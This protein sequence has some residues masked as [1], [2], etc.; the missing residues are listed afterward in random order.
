MSKDGNGDADI[1]QSKTKKG[2]RRSRKKSKRLS[3]SPSPKSEKRKR[4]QKR[5]SKWDAKP[6]ESQIQFQLNSQ[7]LQKQMQS[8]PPGAIPGLSNLNGL[9]MTGVAGIARAAQTMGIQSLMQPQIS[10]LT[11]KPPEIDR[12]PDLEE[13]RAKLKRANR[14]LAEGF[15]NVPE[16]QRSPSPEPIYSEDGKRLNTR[17]IRFKNEVEMERYE[18]MSKLLEKTKF[19]HPIFGTILK[20]GLKDQNRGLE[21]KIWIPVDKMPDYNFAGVII[22]PRGMSQKRLEKESGCSIS[23]RGKG[24]KKRTTGK[25]FEGDD[26]PQHVLIKAPN[27]ECLKKGI[28]VV[29]KALEPQSEEERRKQMRELA[30]LN[31]TLRELPPCPI[32]GQQGHKPMTCPQRNRF[33]AK[34]KCLICQSDTHVSKDC[35]QRTGNNAAGANLMDELGRFM[36]EI[37]GDLG[38][39]DKSESKTPTPSKPK[40]TTPQ[41]PKPQSQQVFCQPIPAPN[42]M[43]M[44]GARPGIGFVPGGGA[45][46]GMG[47]AGGM[48]NAG[49]MQNTAGMASGRG[50]PG[51][52]QNRFGTTARPKTPCVN[53]A[54]GMCRFGARCHFAH[55]KPNQPNMNINP[56]QPSRNINPNQPNM[57][58]NPNQPNMSINPNQPNVNQG[59]R[60][61][62]GQSQ[63]N[64]QRTDYNNRNNHNL[65][66]N[67]NP[68][69]SHGQRVQQMT[70]G[71]GPRNGTNLPWSGGGGQGPQ[72]Q[73]NTPWAQ[74]RNMQSQVPSPQQPQVQKRIP[75][76]YPPQARPPGIYSPGQMGGQPVYGRGRGMYGR[77]MH[78][79]QGGMAP[80]GMAPGGMARGGMARGG[81]APGGMA[82]VG[83]A[84]GGMSRSGMARGGM[85]PGSMNP[86]GMGP[87]RMPARPGMMP[88]GLNPGYQNPRG[89]AY[90]QRPG[91]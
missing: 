32:C 37:N 70:G 67:Q 65:P 88:P 31:G 55:I 74:G 78:M 26:Q 84:P 27:A 60:M 28:E 3:R 49:G 90:Q 29:K 36:A 57:N 5:V 73:Q 58:I 87:G 68:H 21:H 53:F 17:E 20:I 63:D 16:D 82:P 14:K 39:G 69:A 51:L 71:G 22:G 80:G 50:P 41:P 42:Q 4:K 1:D 30:I 33:Q 91:R 19:A 8:L 25:F 59:L 79:P 9:T 46:R 75:P 40:P 34:V 15:K 89:S 7:A 35:P 76:N 66:P 10:I 62:N 77:Q 11:M 81:M 23:L 54:K 86:G 45:G 24:V 52:M 56:N 48:R 47:T 61:T 2:D 13:L 43:R 38:I 18:Y 12:N 72:S 85:G 6:T 83:M 44:Q 64:N